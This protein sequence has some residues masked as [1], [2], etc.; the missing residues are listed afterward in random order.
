M[1]TN[2]KSAVRNLIFALPVL[3]L[4]GITGLSGNQGTPGTVEA[5]TMASSSQATMTG[6]TLSEMHSRIAASNYEPEPAPT[7]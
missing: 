4:V 6:A 1:N 7:F 2:R 3:V 5:T